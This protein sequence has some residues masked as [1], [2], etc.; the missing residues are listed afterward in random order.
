ML[1]LVKLAICRILWSTE[2][3]RSSLVTQN[4]MMQAS[5]QYMHHNMNRHWY[6]S[7]SQRSRKSRVMPSARGH[8]RQSKRSAKLLQHHSYENKYMDMDCTIIL[9]VTCKLFVGT[10]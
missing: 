8:I 9:V 6:Y 10:K 5:R 3:I 1:S 2:S 7:Y 4:W